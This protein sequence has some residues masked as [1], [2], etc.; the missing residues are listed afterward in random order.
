MMKRILTAIISALICVTQI[1]A[2]QSHANLK[3][4]LDK[5]FKILQICN[6]SDE[7]GELNQTN[8]D[9]ITRQIE[10]EKPQIVIFLN[11][12]NGKDASS[13]TDSKFSDICKDIPF[14]VVD[15]DEAKSTAL[16]VRSSDGSSISRI[17]YLIS[18]EPS[19]EQVAWYRQQSKK[20]T[21]QNSDIPIPSLAFVLK[22]L[23]EYE[24]AFKEYGGQKRIKKVISHTGTKGGKISCQENNSGLFT[25][26]Y[27]CGDVSGIFCG[28]DDSND[29]ALVWKNIMLA[30]GRNSK[31]DGPLDF[32]S[33]VIILNETDNKI[34][35][36][37][38]NGDNEV[39]DKCIYPD[40]F[41]ITE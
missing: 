23:P 6:F 27:E 3:F 21:I 8:I 36:Y 37:I 11:G 15:D 2:E 41:T 5:E 39:I 35:S 40:E 33:R 1:S 30:Y 25:S 34:L 17:I 31:V 4:G 18:G 32:G 29:F 13:I 10:V 16:P 22:P 19:F 14:A 9:L 26:M 7:R 24:E 28:Y 20:N 38:R 12:R